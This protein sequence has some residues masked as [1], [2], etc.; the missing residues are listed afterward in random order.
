MVFD[1]RNIEKGDE[2]D[3]WNSFGSC[4]DKDI[5]FFFK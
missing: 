5:M 3:G 2:F 1:C 4:G